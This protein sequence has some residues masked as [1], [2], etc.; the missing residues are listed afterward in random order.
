MDKLD[1]VVAATA[2]ISLR[3]PLLTYRWRRRGT[4]LALRQVVLGT[5]VALCLKH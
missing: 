4:G 2:T 1:I 3:P 5:T